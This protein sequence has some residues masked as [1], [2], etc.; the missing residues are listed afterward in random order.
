M[1]KA[2]VSDPGLFAVVVSYSPR[3]RSVPERRS[4]G[5]SGGSSGTV[6]TVAA[7][8][9]ALR[10]VASS[11]AATSCCR[12][13]SEC[14]PCSASGRRCCDG[15]PHTLLPEEDKA[16][17]SLARVEPLGHHTGE[18]KSRPHGSAR[19]TCTTST[20]SMLRSRECRRLRGGRPISG[21]GKG[22]CPHRALPSLGP[23]APA[24]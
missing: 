4:A 23:S 15:R 2:Q 17:G 14:W 10:T 6:A 5:P 22:C 18:V 7:S 11:P 20:W 24:S 8:W 21:W 12:S 1:T 16:V 19:S 3:A 9:R 13:S